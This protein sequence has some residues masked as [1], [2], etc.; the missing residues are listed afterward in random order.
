M[1]LKGDLR[2][3]K[4]KDCKDVNLVSEMS[5]GIR[6]GRYGQ[7][8]LSRLKLS[9]PGRSLN[10]QKT[11]PKDGGVRGLGQSTVQW[12]NGKVIDIYIVRTR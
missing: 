2:Q 4:K 1:N 11:L 10:P 8:F 9:E 5:G 7:R 12:S 6:R 3:K